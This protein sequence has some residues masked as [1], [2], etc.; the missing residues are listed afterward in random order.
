MT[1]RLDR[2]TAS[3]DAIVTDHAGVLR[4]LTCGREEPV[5]GRYFSIGW[6]KCCGYTMRWITASQLAA[7]EW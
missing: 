1:D 6:P 3:L 2:F 4:C 5:D 7:G